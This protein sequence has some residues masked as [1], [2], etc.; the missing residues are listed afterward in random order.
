MGEFAAD[1]VELTRY[2]DRQRQQ[3]E[4][5][6]RHAADLA[7]FGRCTKC[8]TG[9]AADH[10]HCERCGWALYEF[11]SRVEMCHNRDCELYELEQAGN[12]FGE[13]CEVV[14]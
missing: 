14:D 10:L 6:A 4:T 5:A 9:A 13:E 7:R 12:R 2:V 3:A 1:R 11:G 8:D